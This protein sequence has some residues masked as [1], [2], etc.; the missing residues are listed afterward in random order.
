LCFVLFLEPQYSAC[1]TSSLADV[2]LGIDPTVSANPTLDAYLVPD[3]GIHA[4]QSPDGSGTCLGL[5]NARI[6]CNCPPDRQEFILMVQAAVAAGNLAGT[7]VEFPLDNSSASKKARI[8]TSIVV[9]RNNGRGCPD[10]S[11]TFQAQL[12]AV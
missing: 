11:A 2:S 9:L 4:G 1:L 3:F 6:P 10:S 12:A 7:S 5:N 8:Q